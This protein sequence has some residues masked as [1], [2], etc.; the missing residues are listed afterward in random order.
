VTGPLPRA[1]YLRDTLQVAKDLLGCE[2]VHKSEAGLTSGLIVEVEAYIGPRDPASHAYRG[3]RS[4]RT[5]VQYEEGGRAYVY[6]IYGMYCC[7]NVVT[8]GQ[9]MPEVVLVRALEPRRG[10]PEMRRRRGLGADADLRSLTSGPGRLCQAMG[11]DMASYGLD[12]CSRRL[13]VRAGHPGA[14]RDLVA[15]RRINID[16]AGAAANWRWRFYLK[17]NPF[18][19]RPLFPKRH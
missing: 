4:D 18:V 12:L 13:F 10:I 8:Q 2:L 9:D 15:T 7:F 11:I 17:D 16:Y 14:K 5:R 19:S 3:I 1:F 6:R